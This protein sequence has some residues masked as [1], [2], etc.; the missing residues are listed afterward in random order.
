MNESMSETEALRQVFYVVRN[1]QGFFYKT[2]SNSSTSS[3]WKKDLA[4]AKIYS[5]LSMARATVTRLANRF[6]KQPVP[7]LVEFH[8]SEV[9]VVP[10]EE[11]VA[12]SRLKKQEEDA[13]RNTL[14]AER[15]LKEAESAMQRAQD[16]AESLRRQLSLEQIRSGRH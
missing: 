14:Y 3:G 15:R 12:E 4:V 9:R 6:P 2:Y 10:Q 5:K 13:R 8:V 7:E 11:R 16:E 1:H